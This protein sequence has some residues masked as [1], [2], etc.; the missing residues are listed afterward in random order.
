MRP[1]SFVL[2]QES[3]CHVWMAQLGGYFTTEIFHRLLATLVFHLNLQVDPRNV[4]LLQRWSR[5]YTIKTVLQEIR[6]LMTIKDNMK[7]SQPPEGT[8]F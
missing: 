4:Q 6:R 5:D 1:Q 7:L 2:L 3:I 8:T